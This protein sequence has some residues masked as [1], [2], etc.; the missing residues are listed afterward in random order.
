MMGRGYVMCNCN[1]M[2]YGLPELLPVCF[3][4]YWAVSSVVSMSMP[5]VWY[6]VL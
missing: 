2:D 3:F 5:Y 1:V 4:G 6:V